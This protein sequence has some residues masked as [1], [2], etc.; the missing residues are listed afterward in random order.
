MT[1]Q[2]NVF[3]SLLK[4]WI[5]SNVYGSLVVIVKKS[6]LRMGHSEVMQDEM[7]PNKLTSGGGHSTIFNLS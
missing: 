4:N 3:G 1:I 6:R 7:N 5:S 2:F